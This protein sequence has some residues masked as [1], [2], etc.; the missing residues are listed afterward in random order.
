MKIIGQ[1]QDPLDFINLM[2]TQFDSKDLKSKDMRANRY[3]NL[4]MFTQKLIGINQ[5]L[6]SIISS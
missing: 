4:M 5:E 2:F 6:D 3:H 1:R